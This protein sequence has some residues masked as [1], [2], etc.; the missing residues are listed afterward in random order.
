MP[1]Q[2][3]SGDNFHDLSAI[4]SRLAELEREKQRLIALRAK[5]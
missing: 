4:D 3:R 2:N 5:L 1:D